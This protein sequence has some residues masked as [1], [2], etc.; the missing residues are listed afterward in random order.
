MCPILLHPFAMPDPALFRLEF[1]AIADRLL[2]LSFPLALLGCI[3]LAAI[4][5]AR[6]A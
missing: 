5:F 6:A 3:V 4:F 2:A 1:L